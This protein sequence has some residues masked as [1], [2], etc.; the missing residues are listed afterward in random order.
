MREFLAL[1][2]VGVGTYAMRSVFILR[3]DKIQLPTIVVQGLKYVGPAVLSSLAAVSIAS[4]EGFFGVF[5]FSPE[6]AGLVAC[7]AVAWWKKN[8]VLTVAVGLTVVWVLIEV[9]A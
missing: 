1:F 9:M 6:A 4:G 2:V 3:G 7:V 5:T 8:V